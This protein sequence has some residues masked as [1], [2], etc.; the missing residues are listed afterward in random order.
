M[1]F[2]PVNT[3]K[4]A[5]TG[6][7]KRKRIFLTLAALAAAASAAA[8]S[9]YSSKVEI[10][11]ATISKEKAEEQNKI[12]S[13]IYPDIKVN[14]SGYLYSEE[15]FEEK[16]ANGETGDL[17]S[18]WYTEIDKLIDGD[19]VRDLTEFCKK[20]KLDSAIEP[21]LLEHVSR[22]GKIYAIPTTQYIQGLL[23]NKNL[24]RRAGLVD[25]NGDIMFPKTYDELAE[26]AKIIKEK[27]GV[28]GFAMPSTSND[29]GW[30]FMNIAW[31]YGVTFE[32]QNADGNWEAVFNSPEFVEALKYIRDLRWKYNVVPDNLYLDYK[33]MVKLYANDRLAMFF[34]PAPGQ[35]LV[36]YEN[37]DKDKLMFVR[38]PKGPKGRYAQMGGN[39]SMVMKSTSKEKTEAC[40][41]YMEAIGNLPVKPDNYLETLE[42]SLKEQKEK[43][44]VVSPYHSQFEQ[45]LKTNKWSNRDIDITD[46]IK[47]LYEK[48]S[49]V[50]KKSYEDFYSYED[51]IISPEEPIACQELYHLLDVCIQTV[52]NDKNAN[53]EKLAEETCNKFQRE[54]LDPVNNAKKQSQ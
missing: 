30:H 51:V 34:C 49:T 38:V 16:A 35:T 2:K 37:V 4:G 36:E 12:L 8:C 40:F 31:S 47:K 1:C 20:Y 15:N 27:T 26:Y 48:Y 32:R 24:F 45:Y 28:S 53:L 10:S 29:G 21:G 13:E 7:M 54:Y 14:P 41:K 11:V 25:E 52:L 22:D 44:L 43:G 19:Y 9:H 50:D 5:N 17:I 3:R 6:K 39:V 42:K 33:A 18:T 23:I 46:D